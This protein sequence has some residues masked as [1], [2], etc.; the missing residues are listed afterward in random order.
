[1]QAAAVAA[2]YSCQSLFLW[3]STLHHLIAA[4]YTTKVDASFLRLLSPSSG[5][6]A[7]NRF[8]NRRCL[9]TFKFYQLGLVAAQFHKRLVQCFFAHI[10]IEVMAIV[11]DD[12]GAPLPMF[13]S[14]L[15]RIEMIFLRSGISRFRKPLPGAELRSANARLLLEPF[16]NK[17]T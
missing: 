13:M 11:T 10:I 1:V 5:N 16:Q 15:T 2:V 4:C 3:L 7:S 9:K 14:V 8:N 17:A 12:A 6:L